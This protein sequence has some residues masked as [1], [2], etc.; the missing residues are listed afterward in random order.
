MRKHSVSLHLSLHAGLSSECPSPTHSLIAFLLTT[1][2]RIPSLVVGGTRSWPRVPIRAPE[3]VHCCLRRWIYPYGTTITPLS[4]TIPRV[5]LRRSM[6]RR[7]TYIQKR[8]YPI[9]RC[10]QVPIERP[11]LPLLNGRFRHLSVL[12]PPR[13]RKNEKDQPS[14]S[15]VCRCRSLPKETLTLKK[16]ECRFV[17]YIVIPLQILSNARGQGGKGR[18]KGWFVLL[19]F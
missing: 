18:W 9:I 15:S 12:S 5:A 14:R 13:R 2:L 11:L 3:L 10:Q 16:P 4:K 6:G 17:L 7:H 19:P 1:I 8:N